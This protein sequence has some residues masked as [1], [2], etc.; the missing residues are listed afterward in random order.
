MDLRAQILTENSKWNTDFI[1]NEVG[2]DVKQVKILWNYIKNEDPPLSTRSAWVIENI[3]LSYRE[4]LNLF[5]D[6]I[7]E[8]LTD[9]KNSTIKRH[10][11]KILSFSDLPDSQLGTLFNTC[12]NWIESPEEAVAIKV[13]SLQILYNISEL[14]P[15][16]KPELMEVIQNQ[17]ERESSG[18]KARGS[19]LIDKLRKE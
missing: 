12:L 5:I 3:F 15:G 4:V 8:L 9:L 19:R 7:I 14:E 6:E 18:F 17:M 16:L 13:H 11:L 2:D 1:A 10:L